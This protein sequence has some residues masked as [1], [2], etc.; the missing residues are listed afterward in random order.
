MVEARRDEVARLD[1]HWFLTM[2]R[3]TCGGR[4]GTQPAVSPI[5]TSRDRR[6]GYF[7]RFA[8]PV[9]IVIG[10]RSAKPPLIWCF[11][12]CTRIHGALWGRHR[13][14]R[15]RFWRRAVLELEFGEVVVVDV[16]EGCG[17]AAGEGVAGE[18]DDLQVGQTS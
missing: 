10:Q 7:R 6:Q 4:L 18:P 12:A 1:P 11:P 15:L 2:R 16:A 14:G 13:R 17:D 9:S 3:K 8:G 5:R